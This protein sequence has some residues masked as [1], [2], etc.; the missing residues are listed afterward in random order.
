[1]CGIFLSSE[2]PT[3]SLYSKLLLRRGITSYIECA[4]DGVVA[5]SSVLSIRGHV[6]QPVIRNGYVLQYNGELFNSSE[7]DT[8]S[9]SNFL[10]SIISNYNFSLSFISSSPSHQSLTDISPIYLHPTS[11]STLPS[12]N[13]N[14]I[15]HLFDFL[16]SLYCFTNS[17][18]NELAISVCIKNKAFFY[19]DDIGRRSLGIKHSPF[20]ISSLLYDFELDPLKLY[21]YDFN[22]KL[23]FSKY[24]SNFPYVEYMKVANKQLLSYFSDEKYKYITNTKLIT[25]TEAIKLSEIENQDKH[26]DL[27]NFNLQI[28]NQIMA[29]DLPIDQLTHKFVSKFITLFGNSI[30]MRI[31]GDKHVVYF[32]GGIDSSIIALFLHLNTPIDHKIYLINTSYLNGSDRQTGLNSYE[33]LKRRFKDRQFIL[34]ECNMNDKDSKS[35]RNDIK[36]LAH[37]N[38]A[39]MDLDISL[40]QHCT[41]IQAA[42]LAK[43]VFMGCGADESFCGYRKYRNGSVIYRNKMIFDLL[44]I[45]TN[46]VGRDDRSISDCGVECRYPFLDSAVLLFALSLPNSMLINGT[47]KYKNK[48]LLREV[49]KYYGLDGIAKQAKKALQYGSGVRRHESAIWDG[50]SSEE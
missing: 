44:T 19:K 33:E 12:L 47:R 29:L 41:S 15:H 9:I 31:H 42:K 45:S 16:D 10:D 40:V 7:S 36:L 43:V 17:V 14:N 21:I 1:M 32:S 2:A 38:T 6:F 50:E 22:S 46:N 26:E 30:R 23:L 25:E 34:V 49:L 28:G 3:S 48:Y 8:L 4:H 39:R 11:S 37:P 35:I 20:T 18:E 24:K 5:I 13:L 27:D